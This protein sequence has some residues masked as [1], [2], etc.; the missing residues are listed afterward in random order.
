MNNL[1]NQ[2]PTLDDM[3]FEYRHRQYGAYEIRKAY[4]KNLQKA[5]FWGIFIFGGLISAPLIFAKFN[6]K[7]SIK[8]SAE[9]TLQDYTP[10]IEEE[11]LIVEP[12]KPEPKK[13]EPIETVKFTPDILIVDNTEVDS[14]PIPDQKTLETAVIGTVNIDGRTPDDLITPPE[15]KNPDVAII[16]LPEDETEYVTVEQNPEFIGGMKAFGKY[17]AENMRY[18]NTAVRAG[19]QGRVFV[20]FVVNKDGDITEAKL[21][22]GI[23]FGCDEEALRVVNQM[24]KWNAG[25][26][27][28]KAVRVRFTLP[29]VFRLD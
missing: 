20:V 12:P 6:P 9:H 27:N 22:K 26:Q 15:I 8:Y 5:L 1:E 21:V 11:P 10:P 17:L 25:K 29:I 28:G 4:P 18:P 2:E 3:V 24:P 16:E 13:T 23:G 7:T 19:I 14:E